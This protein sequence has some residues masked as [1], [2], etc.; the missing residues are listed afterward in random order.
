MRRRRQS[1]RKRLNVDAIR[2]VGL[3][4]EPIVVEPPCRFAWTVIDVTP[5]K[6]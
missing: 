6:L 2:L 3:K 4:T 1:E 5:N